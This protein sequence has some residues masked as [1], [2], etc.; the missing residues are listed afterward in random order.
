M[1]A[2]SLTFGELV[3]AW[4]LLDEQWLEM[5]AKLAE[6][7][8]RGRR[9]CECHYCGQPMHPC[10]N[11]SGTRYF[12]HSPGSNRECVLRLNGG[13]SG[14]HH[15]LKHRTFRAMNK[16]ADYTCDVEVQ[17]KTVDEVTG[18]PVVVDVVASSSTEPAKRFGMEIQ[19]S[20]LDEGSVLARHRPRQR[21]LSLCTWVTLDRPSWGQYV[22]WYQ[23]RQRDERSWDVVAGVVDFDGNAHP[24]ISAD[25]MPPLIL[26]G[27]PWVKG[28]GF[29]LSPTGEKRRPGRIS[30]Q[31]R[32][33]GGGGR[34]ADDCRR[35]PAIPLSE[36]EHCD[37][38]EQDVVRVIP[39]YWGERLCPPCCAEANTRFDRDGWP[40]AVG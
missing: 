9:E 1:P 15:S 24:P 11:S 35:T 28:M 19:L 31:L 37:W 27:T 21:E 18:K 14:L 5:R 33:D 6:E 13:E 7:R 40:E 10:Q 4:T 17:L 23:L 29:R 25:E 8:R 38:C 26:R 2:K 32:R 34:V 39:A 30:T 22:P 12:S 16:V 20:R 36:L 3:C